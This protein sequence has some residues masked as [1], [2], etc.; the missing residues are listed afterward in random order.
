MSENFID[1]L[2]ALVNRHK[3]AAGGEP[4]T[5][6][7]DKTDIEEEV[8]QDAEEVSVDT[9]DYGDN[10]LNDEIAR[11]EEAVQ[12]ERRRMWEEQQKNQKEDV[13]MPP[14]DHDPEYH[15][16]AINYQTD[17][18]AIVTTMVNQVV[19][20]HHLTTGGIPDNVRMQV[21]GELIDL[22]HRDGDVITEDFE[23]II[24]DNW[25]GDETVQSTQ[26]VVNEPVVQQAE[27][28]DV[29]EEEKIPEAPTINITVEKGNPVT[30]N[31]DESIL[32]ETTMTKEVNIIVREVSEEE[33]KATTIIENS[34]QE[35][36]I[37]KFDSGIH[38]VPITL[39]LS[40][41]RCVMRPINWFDFIKLATPSSGNNSDNEL[42][43]WSVIYDHMK[44]PSIGEFENFEDFLK[45]TKYQDRELLMWAILVA[46]ADE[47]ETL[48]FE[49]SNPKCRKPISIK[50]H[51][52]SIVHLDPK[53]IPDHYE[54]TH[55]V[56]VGHYAIE[57]FNKVNGKRRRYQL[58]STGIIVEVNEPS[59]YEFITQKLSL[60]QKL[61]ERYRPGEEMSGFNPEDPR[62]MEFDYLSANALFVTA[63]SYQTKDKDGKTKEYR[64]T[65]WDDIER[66]ITE[67]LDAD[68]SGILLKIIEKARTNVT[69]VSFYISDTICP[70]CKLKENKIINDIGNSLLFQVSR[71]LASTQINLIEMD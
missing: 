21:M 22:Y 70:S 58:P 46:T 39:P 30:I 12:E 34:Q 53:H 27:E 69:P 10:D 41:Y 4:V 68:D 15:T 19:E 62:M 18:L 65:N 61:Y 43:K 33:L 16:E 63:M 5:N 51:P 59:A 44:N 26:P 20:K 3:M 47:E 9:I 42:K 50:Y 40:G 13:M 28:E 38:D 67:G 14:D 11:E 60:V 6:V 57:H 45:K 55:S 49:C 48:S 2:A 37:K 71:R 66:I 52:R 35:G 64:Y 56:A 24:L 23:K 31:V 7:N 1:P 29:Q 54:K 8:V 32:P 36:I 25:Q 17:K